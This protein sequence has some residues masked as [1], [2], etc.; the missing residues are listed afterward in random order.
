MRQEREQVLQV[1]IDSLQ[2]AFAAAPLQ[3]E[4]KSF[5]TRLFGALKAVATSG[6]MPPTQ[7]PVCQHLPAAYATARTA[8]VQI[9][10]LATHF[11]AIA[12]RLAWKVRGSGGPNASS[13]W[14]GGHANTVIVGIGGLEERDDVAIGASLLAPNVRYPDHTHP[15]EE[16]YMILTRGNF[17]H[18]TDDWCEL[19][20]GAAFHNPPGIKHAMASMETPLLAIWTMLIDKSA[21]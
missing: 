4:A 13:N 11:A 8:P 16:L 19:G 3:P 7:L 20:P 21:G 14:P 6:N 10:S 12:P 18:G 9:T 1:F 17:Q 15:P 2:S 5:T